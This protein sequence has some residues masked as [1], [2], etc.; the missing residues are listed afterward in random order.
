[1]RQLLVV[2]IIGLLLVVGFQCCVK[3]EVEKM[4]DDVQAYQTKRL[5]PKGW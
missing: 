5:L 2:L 3:D 4:A 1:M